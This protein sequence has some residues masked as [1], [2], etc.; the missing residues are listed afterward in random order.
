MNRLFLRTSLLED[1]FTFT[2]VCDNFFLMIKVTR[3]LFFEQRTCFAIHFWERNTFIC[4]CRDIEE[5]AE[6]YVEVGFLLECV[7]S[8]EWRWVIECVSTGFLSSACKKQNKHQHRCSWYRKNW[9][10]NCQKEN[11]FQCLIWLYFYMK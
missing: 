10:Y 4:R 8:N 6:G 2:K 7:Y 11:L 5:R 3:D 9:F 1:I